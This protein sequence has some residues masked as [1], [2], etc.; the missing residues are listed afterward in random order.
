MPVALSNERRPR[1]LPRLILTAEMLERIRSTLGTPVMVTSGYRSP[2]VNIAV[3]GA[4][5]S[6]PPRATRRHRGPGLARHETCTW[7]HSSAPW[8]SARSSWRA[9]RANAGARQ[10]PHAEK[11]VNCIITITDSGVA[12]GISRWIEHTNQ[13]RHTGRAVSMVWRKVRLPVTLSGRP[14][15]LWTIRRSLCW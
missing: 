11:A 5:S 13:Q 12:V 2:Q 14:L 3:G 10:H 7:R 9:S 1:L 15:A 6:D 8:A 4:T